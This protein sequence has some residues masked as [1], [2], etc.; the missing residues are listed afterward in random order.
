[1]KYYVYILRCAGD[2]FYTGWTNNI[3]H[4][5]IMHNRG[6]GSKYVRSRLPASLVYF[7]ECKSKAEAC[8]KEYLIKHLNRK[9][10]EE[11]VKYFKLIPLRANL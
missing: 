3:V 6:K 4:R 10:K 8:K 9:D 2:T 11:L 1:M 5:I 7:K